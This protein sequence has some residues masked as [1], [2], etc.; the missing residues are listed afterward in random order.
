[1]GLVDFK[2]HSAR[3][4]N[5]ERKKFKELDQ[6][7]SKASSLEEQKHRL[8]EFYSKQT[9]RRDELVARKCSLDN[10]MSFN[11]NSM[12]T[13]ISN[14][15]IAFLGSCITLIIDRTLPT[16]FNNTDGITNSGYFMLIAVSVIMFVCFA[17]FIWRNKLHYDSKYVP[18]LEIIKI[19][20]ER[21]EKELQQ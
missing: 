20:R 3:L 15:L 7:L 9:F 1:M 17:W 4:A 6:L 11:T 13:M 8:D 16:A 18:L 12:T 5:K 2:H 19:E 21:I 14:F 10:K